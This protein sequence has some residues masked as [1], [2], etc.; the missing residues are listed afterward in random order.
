MPL[1]KQSSKSFSLQIKKQVQAFGRQGV[2]PN[3]IVSYTIFKDTI[4]TK[5]FQKPNCCMQGNIPRHSMLVTHSLSIV[6][7]C[8]FLGQASI[9]V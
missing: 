3:Y 1:A 2:L 6:E 4:D 9:H 5:R 7:S 8:S